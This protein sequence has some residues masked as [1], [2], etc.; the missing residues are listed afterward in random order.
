MHTLLPFTTDN[1][2]C[3][4]P[5]RCVEYALKKQNKYNTTTCSSY[6]GCILF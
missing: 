2:T 4:S 3:A 6:I 5:F 1:N